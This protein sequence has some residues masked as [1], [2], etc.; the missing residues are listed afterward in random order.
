MRMSGYWALLLALLLS[1]SVSLAQ[2]AATLSKQDARLN[3]A[4]Q[5]RVAQLRNDPAKL[6]A[7]RHQERS[8]IVQRDHQCGKDVACLMQAAST[9]AGY[10]E[11]QVKQNNPAAKPGNPMPRE[12]LGAWTIRRQLPTQTVACW[13]KK[14]AQ[15]LIGTELEYKPDSLRWKTTTVRYVNSTV[16]AVKAQDFAADNSGSQSYVTFKVLGIAAPEVEQ[17]AIEHPDVTIDDGSKGGTMEMPGDTVLVKSP[18]ALVF[19]VCNVY[20]EAD[21]P[22]KPKS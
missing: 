4:Y 1:A 16:T 5:Q 22:Q 15:A 11:T 12:I 6:A 10:F 3:Q 19:A 8:W 7:L 21:R 9:H 18:N 17:I 13:D 14:Q 20:F 2:D